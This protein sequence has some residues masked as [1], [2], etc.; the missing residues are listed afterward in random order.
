MKV[1]SQVS[2]QAQDEAQ[3]QTDRAYQTLRAAIVRCEYEPGA[4][5]RVDELTQKLSVSSSPLREALSRLAGQGLVQALENR[6][7]RVAPLSQAGL[8]D[9]TRV[10]LL[11]ECETLCDALQNGNDAW[12]S[13]IVAA[14]HRLSLA[15]QRLNG[16]SAILDDD[17]SQRHRAFHMAIYSGARSSLLKSM[18]ENLFDA[19][20]RY[21]RFSA[22]HRK[23]RR[24][25]NA[26]H[27][28]LMRATLSRDKKK[29]V[30]LLKQHISSTE[31]NV[32]A[33]FQSAN[34]KSA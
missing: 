14:A 32:T 2:S 23:M 19:A 28:E 24:N 25:K 20:E 18:V 3:T 21:R 26:E 22:S 11:I 10:R 17:W 4:R 30:E 33:A 8:V 27:Q 29:A 12:E 1:S 34:G 13:E 16:G 31:R 9:L 15:E 7:F 6:G 5:L